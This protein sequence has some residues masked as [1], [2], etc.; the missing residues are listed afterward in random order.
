VTS[1]EVSY[2]T[3]TV[4]TFTVQAA[5]KAW[6]RKSVS[7]CVTETGS[8]ESCTNAVTTTSGTVAVSRVAKKSFQLQVKVA[9]SSANLAAVSPVATY[10]VRATATVSRPN[11]GTLGVQLGGVNGQTVQLQQF[12]GNQWVRATTYQASTKVTVSGVVSGRKYRVVV[13]DSAGIRGVTSAAVA[14]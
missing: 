9:A 7:V 14:A 12:V 10:T 2:G 1:R 6:A 11:R 4:T 13:P 3:S 8:A 5:G